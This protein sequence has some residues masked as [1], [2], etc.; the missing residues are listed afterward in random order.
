MGGAGRAGMPATM[1]CDQM[2]SK[3]KADDTRVATAVSRMNQ[4]Q[5][6]AKIAAMA[7]LLNILVEGRKQMHQMMAACPMGTMTAAHAK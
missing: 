1:N 4:A 3:M 5:G 2:M 6:D 7:D